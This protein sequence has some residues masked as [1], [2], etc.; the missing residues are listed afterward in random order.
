MHVVHSGAFRFRAV[1]GNT[2][3]KHVGKLKW[4]ANV[5]NVVDGQNDE[6]AR[7]HG[8]IFKTLSSRGVHCTKLVRIHVSAQEG[9]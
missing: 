3:L 1:L 5:A 4:M 6:S 2:T 8:N 9:Y 7:V